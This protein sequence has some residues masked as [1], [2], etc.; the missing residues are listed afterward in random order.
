MTAPLHL[1]WV[2]QGRLKLRRPGERPIEWASPFAEQAASRARSIQRKNAWKTQGRGARFAAWGAPMAEDLPNGVEIARAVSVTRG[3]E[4]GELLYVLQTGALSAL[5]ALPP[6][7][8][9][10]LRLHHAADHRI[11]DVAMEPEQDRIAATVAYP[12]GIS[13]LALLSR[14]GSHLVDVTDGDS[15]DAAPRWCGPS[16][17]L[18]QSAGIGRDDAGLYAGRA[19][20]AIFELDLARGAVTEVAEDPDHDLLSPAAGPDGAVWY[21]RR[22]WKPAHAEASLGNLLLDVV[23]FPFRLGRAVLSWLDFFTVR[24]TGRPLITSNPARQGPDERMMFLLGNVVDVEQA[25]RESLK[26]GDAIPALVPQ[27]WEL[28]RQRHGA[29]EVMA[30]GVL[31]FDLTPDGQVVYTNG[32]AIYLLA[33]D[34]PHCLAEDEQIEALVVR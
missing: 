14:D 15:V 2:T 26:A 23:L 9:D 7:A 6:D 22:P 10:E 12:S 21:V 29:T 18:Y 28:V 19:P 30:R 32:R 5:L 25:R 16:R 24:Y 27:S 11:V 3:R 17:L 33:E 4:P 13:N 31:A 8:T 20:F 1:A 34:G